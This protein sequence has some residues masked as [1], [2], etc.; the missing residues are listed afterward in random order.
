MHD[1]LTPSPVPTL[2]SLAD[3]RRGR[4][5]CLVRV[6]RGAGP[7]RAW[8]RGRGPISTAW[9]SS[10]R[11][12][13]PRA[14][15]RRLVHGDVR[16]D[17][18]LVTDDGVVFV[19]WPHG[20]VGNAA[21]DLVAWAPSV[22]LEGGPPPEDLLARACAV[23]AC[24]SRRRHGLAGGRRRLLRV[25][26]PPAGAARAAD[27][28]ALPGRPGRRL[29]CPGCAPDRLVSVDRRPADARGA[30]LGS[31][32][33]LRTADTQLHLW[34]AGRPPSSTGWSSG[35]RRPRRPATT[36]CG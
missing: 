10:S 14:P 30:P 16:S 36:R 27:P 31:G 23:R 9:P 8:N 24:R 21:F 34:R 22:V 32:H 26:L 20:A 35:P 12:G 15:A 5:R 18:V 2:E 13:R 25:A 17:N 1:E 7:P 29:P 28:A 4:L 6:G 19:D 33:A 11:R 3:Y